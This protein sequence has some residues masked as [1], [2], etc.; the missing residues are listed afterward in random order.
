MAINCETSLASLSDLPHRWILVNTCKRMQYLAGKQI[1]FRDV[2]RHTVV[3][4]AHCKRGSTGVPWN[5]RQ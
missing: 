5:K 2:T 1:W 3:M 4:L